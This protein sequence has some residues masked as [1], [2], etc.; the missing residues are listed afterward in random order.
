[1]VP[2]YRHRAVFIWAV[3]IVSILSCEL[4][5]VLEGKLQL[6]IIIVDLEVGYLVDFNYLFIKRFLL[7]LHCS[8]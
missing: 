1:M 7:F 2:Q 3:L 4:S 5:R 8:Q 6:L